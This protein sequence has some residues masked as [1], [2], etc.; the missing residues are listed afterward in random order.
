MI[1]NNIE[2]RKFIIEKINNIFCS[3]KDIKEIFLTNEE[4]SHFCCTS[5]AFYRDGNY[6]YNEIK[7]KE[8]NS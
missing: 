7:I 4:Y 2:Y 6:Y 5:E 8:S 3:S 1:K